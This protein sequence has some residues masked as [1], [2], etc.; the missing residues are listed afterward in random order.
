MTYA[1]FMSNCSHTLKIFSR[2]RA[3]LYFPTP[4]TRGR[5]SPIYTHI[6][7]GEDSLT[8]TQRT[9]RAVPDVIYPRVK[10]T[11]PPTPTST[12]GGG[13]LA[14]LRGEG[15]IDPLRLFFSKF[16]HALRRLSSST[17]NS[18]PPLAI[19]SQS[20][21]QTPITTGAERLALSRVT[22]L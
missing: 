8:G 3:E 21:I 6:H 15:V 17:A 13:S 4:S 18:I 7:G 14:R 16:F 20:N 11:H 9:R 12:E 2:V 22:T 19:K 10:I 5:T 1:F